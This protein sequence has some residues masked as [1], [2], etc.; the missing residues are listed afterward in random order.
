M[1]SR[2][3][4]SSPRRRETLKHPPFLEH[5][6]ISKAPISS[7]PSSA[8]NSLIYVQTSHRLRRTVPQCDEFPLLSLNSTCMEKGTSPMPTLDDLLDKY[9]APKVHDIQFKVKVHRKRRVQQS[10]AVERRSS[11][12][13]EDSPDADRLS[14]HRLGYS[15]LKTP[16]KPLG[17]KLRVRSLR[18]TVKPPAP[19]QEVA[20]KP[21]VGKGFYKR[22]SHEDL[23]RGNKVFDFQAILDIANGQILL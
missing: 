18:R 8:K 17:K 9:S 7:R 21:S 13:P 2:R 16:P 4:A 5:M 1:H 10:E 23:G 12:Q 6:H 15:L 14:E 11:H 19:P 20:R 22:V 3:Y